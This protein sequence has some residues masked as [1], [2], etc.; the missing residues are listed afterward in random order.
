MSAGIPVACKRYDRFVIN[1]EVNKGV[2]HNFF[3]CVVEQNNASHNCM[4]L[5]VAN[6]YQCP[7]L[8]SQ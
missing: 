8:H 1:A 5:L 2:M 3:Y 6:S 7:Q 4:Q